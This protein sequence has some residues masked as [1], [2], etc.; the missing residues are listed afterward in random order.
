MVGAPL[1]APHRCCTWRYTV[2]GCSLHAIPRSRG[3]AFPFV[4]LPC[5]HLS[6]P[7]K[8]HFLFFPRPEKE[9]KSP[10][11]EYVLRERGAISANNGYGRATRDRGRRER[12]KRRKEKKKGRPSGRKEED[13]R[14]ISSLFSPLSSSQRRRNLRASTSLPTYLGPWK[15]PADAESAKLP[16]KLGLPPLLFYPPSP[17]LPPPPPRE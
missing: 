12:E 5:C 14:S 16:S 11:L 7:A 13:V 17:F 9:E 3:R 8:H 6:L 4:L 15:E 1:W 2:C 10:A